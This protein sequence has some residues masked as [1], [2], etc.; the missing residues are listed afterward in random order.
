[1]IDEICEEKFEEVD[2]L[3]S[4]EDLIREVSVRLEN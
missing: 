1:M 2:G 4:V 3:V